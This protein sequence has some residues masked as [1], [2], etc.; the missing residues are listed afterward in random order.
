MPGRH[1][2]YHH[3]FSRRLGIWRQHC[4][5]TETHQ[6]AMVERVVFYCMLCR[7]E[8]HEGGSI[9]GLVEKAVGMPTSKPKLAQIHNLEP[10]CDIPPCIKD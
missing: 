1:R 4:Q 8:F 3:F 2:W 6:V 5:N 10:T 7:E 9:T